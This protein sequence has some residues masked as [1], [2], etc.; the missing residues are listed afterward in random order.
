MTY[1]G[2]ALSEGMVKWRIRKRPLWWRSSY[3]VQKAERQVAA[4]EVALSTEGKFQILF[5]P[6]REKGACDVLSLD[7][8][9]VIAT[10]TDSK[11]ESQE[12][13]YSFSVSDNG[14]YL[15]LDMADK[16]VRDSAVITVKASTVNGEPVA[17][18]G[19]YTLYL[20][21]DKRVKPDN[22]GGPVIYPIRKMVRTGQFTADTPISPL[23]TPDMESGRYRIEARAFDRNGKQVEVKRDFILYDLADKRP[24]VFSE[25]W[26][27]CQQ[28]TCAVGEEGRF[29]VGT[30][31]KDTY[32]Y[33]EMYD[34]T[35][36]TL[37][38]ELLRMSDENQQFSFPYEERFGEGVTVSLW[39][40][41]EQRLYQES[42][43]IRLRRPDR[44]LTIRPVTF[45]DH[46]LPGSQESWTFQI[47]DADSAFVESEVLAS[48]YDASLDAIHSSVWSFSPVSYVR[49]SQPRLMTG[50]N[51]STH[52][53]YG[54]AEMRFVDVPVV[55]WVDL[56][57]QGVLSLGY[58]Y[59]S[60]IQGFLT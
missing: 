10:L 11:C 51:F 41:K 23:V 22:N 32:G 48:L 20:L 31:F 26:L 42:I 4:G 5:T 6:E 46:L 33:Y 45:R 18:K 13:H 38:R 17:A 60:T 8:D 15:T 37:S 55:K 36:K 34:R 12:A 25:T 27:L 40:V 54:A 28:T 52:S 21:E 58:F 35:G 57:W 47:K 7:H 9:E 24:P 44:Q 49:L 1:S 59:T 56:E 30:S 50:N 3:F 14:M 39:F 43:G 16:M 53:E 2:V 29:L 19:N